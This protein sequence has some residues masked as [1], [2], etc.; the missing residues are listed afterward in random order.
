MKCV[1]HTRWNVWSIQQYL[2]KMLGNMEKFCISQL[3]RGQETEGKD[4]VYEKM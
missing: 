1:A 2:A 3:V 4:V